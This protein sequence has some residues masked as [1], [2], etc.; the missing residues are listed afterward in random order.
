MTV[1]T[2]PVVGRESA[3]QR[4]NAELGMEIVALKDE[5]RQLAALAPYALRVHNYVASQGNS[6]QAEQLSAFVAAKLEAAGRR[7]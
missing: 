7:R 2:R 5:R 4:R 3:L 6:P 1:A